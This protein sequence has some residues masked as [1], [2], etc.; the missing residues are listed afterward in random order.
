MKKRISRWP[1]IRMAFA[2]LSVIC[3]TTTVNILAARA[4]SLELARAGF[5]ARKQKQFV[6]AIQ[7]F[8][9][10]LRQGK[11]SKEQQGYV[12]YSRGV[13]YDALGIHDKALSDFDTA[14]ALMPKFPNSYIYRGLIWNGLHE[15]DRAIQ[16]FREASR[17]DPGDPLIYN[18]L[19]GAYEGKG[20]VD[21]AIDAFNQA[22]KVQPDSAA[23]YYN[24]AHAYHEKGSDA[25]AMAD[26][27]H[28][29]R[30]KPDFAE[31]YGN[32]AVLY[33]TLGQ[34][35]RAI[36]DFSAAVRLQPTNAG[37]LTNRANAYLTMERYPEALAD[38]DRAI[39]IDPGQA[40]FYLGRGRARL[41]AGQL[42]ASTTDFLTAL[43]IRPENPYPVI[44]LHMARTHL[45]EDDKA[46]FSANAKEIR[47]DIWPGPL[48]DFYLGTADAQQ[49]RDTSL[50]GPPQT[51]DNRVCEADFFIGD[52]DRHAGKSIEARAIL[53][54]VTRSCQS[55]DTVYGA[56][57]AELA[58]L[59]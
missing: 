30:L 39:Q 2:V 51:K 15:Y 41:Y 4:D 59:R 25:D 21:R 43:R 31:A 23:S 48:L 14:I 20:D 24:R 50:K 33:L 36:A 56:A 10:A 12:V 35:D 11:F 19:A 46:E 26:Y 32:R 54:D 1:F 55:H 22:I 38:F 40:A 57:K 44:W 28:A 5:A 29:I 3:L 27:D 16:D 6:A 37:F 42:A 34:S 49:V 18:N 17:L 8:D 7:Y 47:R 45:G 52:S 58:L 13:S 53:Q 9:A